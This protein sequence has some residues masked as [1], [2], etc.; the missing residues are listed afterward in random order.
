MTKLMYEKHGE[1]INARE[2]LD[3]LESDVT[4]ITLT[5]CTI[6]GVVDL[7]S[8]DIERDE[9]DRI[10]LNKS[11]SCNG[12]RFTNVVNF[13]SVVFQKEL[14][15]RR[16]IF[17]ADLDFDEATL[18]HP[19]EFREATFHGRANFHG[20]V[21]HKS[22]SFWRA[23][24]HNVADFHQTQFNENA[25][26]HEAHFQKEANF[27]RVLFQQTLDC[28]G[29]DFT[30]A[31]VFNRATF[32]STTRFTGAKFAAVA[33]FRDVTYIPNTI[34]QSIVNRFSKNGHRP[35]QFYLDSQHVDEV[36]NPFFKRYV[37]DQQFIRA[38][39]K[40][41]PMLARLWRWSSDYGRN[42]G[43]WAFWSLFF[44]LLFAIAYMP[45]PSWLPDWIQEWSPQFHQATGQYSGESLTFWNSFYFSIVT[46][47]TLGFGDVVADNA[48]ARFLVTMEVIFGY[49]ML[50]GLISIF[51]N[52]LASRS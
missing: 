3:A 38:F 17:E 30:D 14:S 25:V 34:R 26:F 40:A 9:N 35:T 16:S 49:L 5:T 12:C 6:E 44:A 29:T 8:S 50:G 27:S 37:A 20:V 43:L 1:T 15:F 48:T 7:F 33:S 47:T 18:Q 42:L 36:A 24:F 21:F 39:K 51:A 11:L 13:R 2:F 45:F 41:N 22:V 19:C 46:F 10:F 28:T 23:D 31:A 32:V 52:K 4:D